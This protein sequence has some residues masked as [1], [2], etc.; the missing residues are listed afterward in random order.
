LV[1]IGWSRTDARKDRAPAGDLGGPDYSGGI[2]LRVSVL[3]ASNDILVARLRSF[4]TF[5]VFHAAFQP[6]ASRQSNPTFRF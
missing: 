5:K 3:S 1:N 2:Q 4:W 6:D